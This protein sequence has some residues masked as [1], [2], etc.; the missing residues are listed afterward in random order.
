MIVVADSSPLIAFSRI[1][2]I[3]LLDELFGEIT[4]PDAVYD[5]LTTGGHKFS[6]GWIK[7]KGVN[8]KNLVKIL[9]AKLD[10]GESEAIALAI[11][12]NAD[13]LI[14]DEKPGSR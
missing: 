14:M 3:D 10:R 6:H 2:K 9:N 1:G 4:I 13:I 12:I 8:D 5:E 11:E 7:R